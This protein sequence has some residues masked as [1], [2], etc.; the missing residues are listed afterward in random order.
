[1]TAKSPAALAAGIFAAKARRPQ[2][3]WRRCPL[4]KKA[5]PARGDGSNAPMKFARVA[6]GWPQMRVWELSLI[7]AQVRGVIDCDCSRISR[8]VSKIQS[9]PVLGRSN[10]LTTGGFLNFQWLGGLDVAAPG[11]GCAPYGR[12]DMLKLELQP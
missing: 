9:A 4:R 7:R 8:S 2:G 12:L 11:D 1:M 6:P 10:G 3:S 5:S